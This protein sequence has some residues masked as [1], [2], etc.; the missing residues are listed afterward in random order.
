[1]DIARF[2][3][4]GK[5]NTFRRLVRALGIIDQ[6]SVTPH[7]QILTFTDLRQ[8]VLHELMHPDKYTGVPMPSLP[9]F[10]KLIEGFRRGEL[11]V[12]TD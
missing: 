1:M 5:R 8:V 10:T 11:T 6:A 3:H 2:H 12:L 9:G 7:E 4:P